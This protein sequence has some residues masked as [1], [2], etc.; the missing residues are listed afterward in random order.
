[1]LA[2]FAK[3]TYKQFCTVYETLR[4]VVLIVQAYPNELL[5]AYEHVLNKHYQQ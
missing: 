2:I 4:A 3:H 5:D 1:M